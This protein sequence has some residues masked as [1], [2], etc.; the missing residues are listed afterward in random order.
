M[1]KKAVRM[2]MTLACTECGERNYTKKTAAMIRVSNSK[3]LF[4]LPVS[5]SSRNQV[6]NDLPDNRPRQIQTLC[7][8]DAVSALGRYERSA[9]KWKIKSR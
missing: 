8:N 3:I 9:L 2:V 5:P 7:L 4:T 1:A 6:I